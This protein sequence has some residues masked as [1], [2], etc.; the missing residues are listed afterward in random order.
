[1]KKALIYQHESTTTLAKSGAASSARLLHAKANEALLAYWLA[2]NREERTKLLDQSWGHAEKA[3]RSFHSSG[4]PRAFLETFNRFS[5]AVASSIEFDG[6]LRSRLRKLREATE[7]AKEAVIVSRETGDEADQAKAL[8][9]AAI[10]LDALSDDVTDKEQ[11]ELRQESRRSWDQAFA[12]FRNVALYEMTHPLH[13]SQIQDPNLNIKLSEE[14]LGVVSPTRD[15]FAIGRLNEYLA[16]WTFYGAESIAGGDPVQTMKIHAKAL[17]HAEESAK[18]FERINYTSPS[19]GVMWVH[20]P[21]TEYFNRIATYETNSDKRRLL[22]QKG[23]HSS[24]ELLRLAEIRGSPRILF[25]AYYNT[26]K[27]KITVAE[28]EK[29]RRKRKGLLKEALSE[30]IQSNF[31]TRQIFGSTSWNQHVATRGV[32]DAQAQLSE[33][34]DDPLEKGK[35]LAAAIRNQQRS[36]VQAFSHTKTIMTPATHFYSDSIGRVFA[37]LGDL[38]LRNAKLRNDTNYIRKAA[39]SYL[40]AAEWHE[41]IPRYD[42]TAEWYW[43]AAQCFDELQAY[44]VAAEYFAKASRSYTKLG[45]RVSTLVDYSREYS[46]YLAAWERIETARFRHIKQ[47]FEAASGLYKQASDLHRVTRRWSFLAPY[48]RACSLLESGED[49]SR[50]GEHETATNLFQEAAT[51]F[52]TS[53]ESFKARMLQ[54]ERP[55]ESNLLEKLSNSSRDL[56]CQSR[57]SLEK[58]IVAENE[59]DYQ[60]SFEQYGLASEGFEEASSLSDSDEDRKECIFLSTLCSA[61]KCATNAELQDSIEQLKKARTL[62]AKARSSAPDERSATLAKGHEAFCSGMIEARKFG[63]SQD[64][65][66]HEKATRELELAHESYLQAGFRTAAHHANARKLL[67]NA[68]F[69]LSTARRES[70]VEKRNEL[71]SMSKTLLDES[72]VEFRKAQQPLGKEQALRLLATTQTEAQGSPLFN[73]TIRELTQPLTNP[74]FYTRPQGIERPVGLERFERADIETNLVRLATSLESHGSFE[75][76]IGISN[77]GRQPIKLLRVEDATP[78]GADLV[79]FPDNWKQEG[80]SLAHSSLL[81]APTKS[82]KLR[83]VIRP[84]NIGLLSVRPKIVFIDENGWRWERLTKGETFATSRMIEYLASSFIE[85]SNR[86]LPPDHC[87]WKSMMEVVKDLRIPRSHVY[88]PHRY[89]RVFGKQLNSLVKSSLVEYRIFPEERGRGGNITR[90]RIQI[91]N[92]AVRRYAEELSK[93]NTPQISNLIQPASTV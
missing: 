67:L 3:L 35:L 51:L 89:G 84:R 48:Y 82:E 81:L 36:L 45:R 37:G 79:E 63:D 43:K 86:H 62:F 22:E 42:R 49:A 66:F 74:V 80:N 24:A 60:T 59:Q 14:A 16:K 32:A 55:E 2:T 27:I 88:G 56:Y 87:G 52:Q 93:S 44:S 7:F 92:E 61:W 53:K 78:E 1:M 29:N 76:E 39:R 13:G 26:S 20:S 70:R 40:K 65:A 64:P 73:D 83:L 6:D 9:R 90:V 10:F 71:Y 57:V 46:R 75:F 12:T 19:G 33:L 21:Y 30:R 41:K 15:N 47:Q 85:D 18:H 50:K 58:A 72:A 8:M 54:A 11:Q 23:L 38:F 5:F 28:K 91:D 25:Y 4:D 34:E 31:K 77:I 69:L 17:H 68:S